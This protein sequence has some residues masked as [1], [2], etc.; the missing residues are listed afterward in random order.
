M[1]THNPLSQGDREIR[2][3]RF[4]C[5]ATGPVDDSEPISLELQHVSLN[6]NISYSAA[7]YTWGDT[8]DSVMIDINGYP[9]E[10]TLNLHEALK[11]FRRDGLKS[12]LWIDAICIEQSN[13][14]E[15]A[16]QIMEMRE[17][18]GQAKTVYLWLGTGTVES[19]LT[20]DFISRVGTTAPSCDVIKSVYR[21]SLRNEINS[22][23]EQSCLQAS[24]GS[25]P[26]ESKLG[27]FY[28]D[29]LNEDALRTQSPLMTGIRNILQRNYWHRIWIVQEVVLAKEA[30][31]VVGTKSVSLEAFDATFS[32]IWRCIHSGAR[33]MRPEWNAFCDGLS[34]NLYRIKSLDTR[35]HLR[36]T[37]AT[38]PIRL[39]D[40]LWEVRAAPGRPH[41]SATDPRDILFGLL[42]I[43]TE[44][45]TKGI[46]VDY[47][48]SVAQ[49][50]TTLTRTLISSGDEDRFSFHLDF[51]NPGDPTG[52]LPTWVPD[53]QEIGN[54]GVRT[55]RINHFPQYKATGRSLGQVSTLSVEGD[56]HVLYRFGC[57]V[58]VITEVMH[59]PEWIQKRRYSPSVINDADNWF[60]SIAAFT[61]LGSESGPGEDYIWRTVMA[62]ESDRNFTAPGEECVCLNENTRGLSR[63]IMRVQHVD[64]ESLTDQ[65]DKYIRNGPLYMDFGSSSEALND[66]QVSLFAS[67]RRWYLGTHN[68]NRTLFKTSK[69]MLGLGHV[70]I[71]T[72]DIVTLIWGVCSPIILRQRPGGGFY[73]LG[74]AYVDGIMQGEYLENG[75]VEEEFF[76]Y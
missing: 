64:A 3:L 24:D 72:G 69:G 37:T 54:W 38:I 26:S 31:V 29:L 41:Y 1:F 49:V 8:T 51:C 16:S 12:W 75:P 52:E 67:K 39:A 35:R 53:W 11:Q 73:F 63:K 27:R 13:D 22:Y 15:K 42:G 7:S 59:P 62:L 2:L 14:L 44:E 56:A 46:L 23:I 70:G 17:I 20:I 21:V 48:K 18:F 55:Y 36:Q 57:R 4:T 60:R 25:T 32:A 9:F 33:H 71:E 34:G 5:A 30:L 43:L 74:D 66:Q 65:E 76:I 50:F 10:I 6:D 19:D 58:D 68:R 40:V 28:Y 61:K 47:T 45:Q